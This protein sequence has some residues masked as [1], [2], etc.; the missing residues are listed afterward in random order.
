[1]G[2]KYGR[3][4]SRRGSRER[5]SWVGISPVSCRERVRPRWAASH[6]THQPLWGQGPAPPRSPRASGGVEQRGARWDVFPRC[7][8]SS[9]K[10]GRVIMGSLRDTKKLEWE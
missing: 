9:S 1:M 4:R 10:W 8:G 7:P 2:K 3:R 5:H 6:V